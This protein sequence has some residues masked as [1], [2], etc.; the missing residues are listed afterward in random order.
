MRNQK[1][2]RR[3]EERG[4]NQAKATMLRNEAAQ[5]RDG[6]SAKHCGAHLVTN[7]VNGDIAADTLRGSGHETR[8]DHGQTESAQGKC[9]WSR[10]WKRVDREECG[11]RK[12]GD[13]AQA[14]EV[15]DANVIDDESE[16]NSAH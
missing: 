4:G 8:E 5:A 2:C 16:D 9:E 7:R 14:D 10:L 11:T 13:N 3:D 12:C 1:Y 15:I 6:R